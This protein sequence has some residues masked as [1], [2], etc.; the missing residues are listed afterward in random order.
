MH[1][2][3]SADLARGLIAASR[4]SLASEGKLVYQ[5]RRPWCDDTTYFVL[6]PLTFI[7]RLAALVPSPGV[8]LVTNHGVLAPAS[9]WRDMIV[10][11]P[12]PRVPLDEHETVMHET[13]APRASDSGK[14]L[15]AP[16]PKP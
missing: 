5:L 7:E 9:T 2:R 6:D 3:E 12:P 16:P 4:L 1:R 8:H 15:R 10:P 14:Q 13:H 11:A